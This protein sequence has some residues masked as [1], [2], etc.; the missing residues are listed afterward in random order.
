MLP[1]KPHPEPGYFNQ[2]IREPGKACLKANPG[3]NR[4]KPFWT[5]C[6]GDMH[7][8]YHGICCYYAIYI[9]LEN[10]ASTVDHFKPKNKY[11]DYAYE[12]SNFRF[13]CLQA[14][15]RKR[16]YEDIIDPMHLKK[17]ILQLDIG[18]G[19]IYYS[20]QI[21]APE[22]AL[23]ES[24]IDRLKL[25]SQRMCNMRIRHL[26]EYLQGNISGK[27]LKTRSP[28]VYYEAC[29]QGII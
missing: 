25:N 2:Q 29:R 1:V 6:L 5:K 20:D 28:F 14:N 17:D 3:K 23:L 21:S 18:S 9:E 11:P 27:G 16:D 13:C 19:E 26:A 12:W 7:S 8:I 24:T 15:R 22:K 10:G 4:L